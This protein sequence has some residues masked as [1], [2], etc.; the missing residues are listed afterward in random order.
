MLITKQETEL[1]AVKRK[2]EEKKRN[3]NCGSTSDKKKTT[4]NRTE[5]SQRKAT[6]IRRGKFS[7]SFIL[8]FIWKT[9]EHF[10]TMIESK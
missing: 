6:L 4:S 5:V 7:C 9:Y 2:L 3:C 1:K 8:S 10:F